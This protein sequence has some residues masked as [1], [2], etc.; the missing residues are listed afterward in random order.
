MNIIFLC[1]VVLAEELPGVIW[2]V[3]FPGPSHLGV[4]PRMSY[5]LLAYE[6]VQ[7]SNKF[8]CSFFVLTLDFLWKNLKCNHMAHLSHCGNFFLIHVGQTTSIELG[9]AA[10]ES[11]VEA[12]KVSHLR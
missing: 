9:K 4:H 6:R 3:S 5:S 10:E 2:T 11:A 8:A 1:C 12:V 7:A